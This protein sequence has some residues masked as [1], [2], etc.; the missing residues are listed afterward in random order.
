MISKREAAIISAYTGYHIGD[1]NETHRYIEEI[2]DR[3]VRTHE[4]A[5]TK[6]WEEIRAKA[7]PDFSALEV[8]D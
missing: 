2:L 4:M 1:F 7:K 3:P 6:L 8:Q 5:S